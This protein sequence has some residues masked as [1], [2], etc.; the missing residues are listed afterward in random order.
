MKVASRCIYRFMLAVFVLSDAYVRIFWF[1]LQDEREKNNKL[2]RE[3]QHN[4]K[5]NEE[6]LREVRRLIWYLCVL[7]QDTSRSPFFLFRRFDNLPAFYLF[8][9]VQTISI[10]LPQRL[11]GTN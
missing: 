3:L 9:C 8:T 7:G 6:S 2:A 10:N 5:L 1:K 11:S 4:Q